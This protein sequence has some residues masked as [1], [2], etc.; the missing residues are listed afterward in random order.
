MKT[1]G[2]SQEPKVIEELV[3]KGKE[4]IQNYQGRQVLNFSDTK[5]V[6]HAVFNA[7]SSHKEVGTERLLGAIFNDIGFNKIEDSLFKYLVFSRLIQPVSKLKTT[8]YLFL[9]KEIEISSQQIYR[10]LDRLHSRL[11]R[12]I[13][14]HICISFVAYKIH[15]ELDRQLKEKKAK[16]SANKAIEIAKTIYSITAKLPDG[17]E[18]EHLLVTNPRQ[19]QLMNIFPE[20]FG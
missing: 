6:F 4:Y 20:N 3:N 19:K 2:S 5:S 8:E 14:V 13:E 18:I 15:R 9:Y 10:Y 17:T 11:Q 7:V 1:I 12:R 16:I